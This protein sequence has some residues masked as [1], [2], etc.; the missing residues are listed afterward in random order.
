MHKRHI[1]VNIESCRQQQHRQRDKQGKGEFFHGAG[2][3][4]TIFTTERTV[5]TSA[6]DRSL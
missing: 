2:T 4:C 1:V 3:C 5:N 6:S